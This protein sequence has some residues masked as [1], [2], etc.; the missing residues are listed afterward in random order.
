MTP[1]DFIVQARVDPAIS[2]ATDRHLMRAVHRRSRNRSAVLRLYSFEGDLL[3]VGRYHLCPGSTERVG[4]WRRA[5]G[6]RALPFGDGFV[7]LSFILPHRSALVAD[8]PLAL[9]PHQ[10]LNRYVRGIMEACRLVRLPVYYP[11]RDVI[12]VNGRILGLVSF[13]TDEQQTLLFEAVIANSRDFSL[14]ADFLDAVDPEGMVK[15]QVLSADATTCLARELGTELPVEELAELVLRGFSGQFDLQIETHD[16]SPLERQAIEAVAVHEFQPEHWLAHERVRDLGRHSLT[17]AQL[18]AVEA[19]LS[20]AQ[21]RF[22]KDFL[23][24]G[25]FIANSPAVDALGRELRLCPLEW[26]AVHAVVQEV[27][28]RPHNFLLGLG[29]LRT[30]TD[31]ILRGAGQ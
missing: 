24:V 9:A 10:V 7:G 14:L 26:H 30:L 28:S 21:D 29:P 4:S 19:Y 8:D 5:T 2:A 3:S 25:D 23:L 16:L 27:F 17:W 6:G 12:T 20:L 22:I 11:G 13:E 18:G 15:A 1:V 31:L